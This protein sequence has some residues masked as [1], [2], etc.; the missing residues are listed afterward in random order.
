MTSW[1]LA[2]FRMTVVLTCLSTIVA[3]LL[4]VSPSDARDR[5][6]SRGRGNYVR[7][8]RHH[9]VVGIAPWWWWG[10]PY[11]YWWY[12]PRPYYAYPPTVVVEEPPVY[13]SLRRRRRHRRTG[14]GEFR[15]DRNSPRHPERLGV[16]PPQLRR[17]RNDSES[18][19]CRP[20]LEF[21][22]MIALATPMHHAKRVRDYE[23]GGCRCVH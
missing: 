20:T 19:P 4:A 10:P 17:P 5:A 21:S 14:S 9:V 3:L 22:Y 12:Y 6:G 23:T 7:P 2:P 15:R 8:V 16:P 1:R 13:S 11:P 18:C